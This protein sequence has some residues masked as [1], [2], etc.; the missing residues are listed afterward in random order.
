MGHQ[1]GSQINGL[2][3]A[4]PFPGTQLFELAVANGYTPP[5]SLDEWGNID[6]IMSYKNV[7]YVSREF[8]QKLVVFAFLVRFRYLW[9]HSASFLKNKK[10]MATFKYWGLLRS[11]FFFRPLTSCSRF[12]GQSV[13]RFS[14]RHFCGALRSFQDRSLI[15]SPVIAGKGTMQ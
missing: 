15:R 6:F 3:F 1:P 9:M 13:Y 14:N 8:T 11:A 5:L 10:N 12:A 7:P 4:T 2:F